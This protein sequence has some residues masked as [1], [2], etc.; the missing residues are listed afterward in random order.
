MSP[1][2]N[3]SPNPSP[4]PSPMSTETPTSS[5]PHAPV[6]GD[7][8]PWEDLVDIFYAP[9][10][11]FARRLADPVIWLPLLVLV[12]AISALSF[13]GA[14][15]L[16]PMYEAEFHRSIEGS[17]PDGATLS[18]EELDRMRGFSSTIGMI[19]APITVAVGA[20]LL[21]LVIWAVARLFGAAPTLGAT[22][23]VGVL[24]QFPRILQQVVTIV[25]GAIMSP[26]AI[27]SRFALSAGPARFLD[28]V[29]TP[30]VVM[31]TLERFDLFTL[32]VT[33]LVG[34][35]FH[36]VGRLPRVQAAVAAFVVWLIAGLPLLIAAM[37]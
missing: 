11:V 15:V 37:T 21:G 5:D 28:P 29:R 25:Q 6:P 10:Q 26:E 2:W 16:E 3:P 18:P 14:G 4:L 7:A 9:A 12:A 1:G 30:E 24:S 8:A 20:L 32:W 13:A 36:V 27:H 35:G 19:F 33:V 34:V 22:T 31:A 23:M 17:A